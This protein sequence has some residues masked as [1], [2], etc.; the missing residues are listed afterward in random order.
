MQYKYSEVY[1]KK[2]SMYVK[3][4]SKIKVYMQRY[5]LVVLVI[6]L[7]IELYKRRIYLLN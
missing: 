1:N 7:V 6:L 2:K 4:Y 5:I 3:V